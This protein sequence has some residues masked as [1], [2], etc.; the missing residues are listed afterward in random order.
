MEFQVIYVFNLFCAG[1]IIKEMQMRLISNFVG[2]S[3][4]F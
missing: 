2:L 3:L 4:N 1:F